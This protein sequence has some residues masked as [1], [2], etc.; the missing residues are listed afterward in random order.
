MASLNAK[1]KRRKPYNS[2]ATFDSKIRSCFLDSYPALYEAKSREVREDRRSRRIKEAARRR[3]KGVGE[4]SVSAFTEAAIGHARS[5]RAVI[6]LRWEL[7]FRWHGGLVGGD[8]RYCR[9]KM[10]YHGLVSDEHAVLKLFAAKVPRA[11]NLMTGDAKDVVEGTDSK[12]LAL[13]CAYVECGKDLRGVLRVELDAVLESW[14]AIAESCR[15]ACI[16]LPNVAVGHQDAQG[17]ILNPHLIWMLSASVAFTASGSR[18]ARSLFSGVLRGLTAALLPHGADPGGILNAMRVK[19]PL[20]PLWSRRVFAEVPYAL[21]WNVST[22]GERPP[23]VLT[24]REHVDITVRL[25]TLLEQPASHPTADHPDPDVASQ[26]NRLFRDLATWSR[27]A[28][29]SVR[30]AGGGQHEFSILVAEEAYRLAGRTSGD[31]RRSERAVRTLATNVSRWTWEHGVRR[32]P[33]TEPLSD[34]EI[35]ERQAEGRRKGASSRKATTQAQLQEAAL[36]VLDGGQKL[37]QAALTRESGRGEGTVRRH[38]HELLAALQGVME[39]RSQSRS[40]SPLYDKKGG[41][42]AP[43]LPANT[44]PIL[45]PKGVLAIKHPAART[46]PATVCSTDA[47]H[48]V[49][50]AGWD[51][52]RSAMPVFPMVPGML[53][54]RSARPACPLHLRNRGDHTITPNRPAIPMFLQPGKRNC[55]LK[56]P[57]RIMGPLSREGLRLAYQVAMTTRNPQVLPPNCVVRPAMPLTTASRSPA[58]Y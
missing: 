56:V 8:P 42:A 1:I 33:T 23:G 58:K 27:S 31:N 13:D 21:D 52:S 40:S 26:S 17:R 50:K 46:S 11:R 39:N 19:N 47:K 36:R 55:L 2:A 37:T 28:F 6:D 30:A 44:K 14:D 4:A 49:A 20:S 51:A 16:P 48:A 57:E 35:K 12:L 29:Q 9:E 54:N 3:K 34:D 38:W 24:L 7:G 15:A 53:D 43:L 22:M 32:K 25:A 10:T 41:E 45:L 18:K 5:R